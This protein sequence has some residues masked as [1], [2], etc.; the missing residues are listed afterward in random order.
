MAL[1]QFSVRTETVEIEGER[2]IVRGMYRVESLAIQ[3]ELGEDPELDEVEMRMLA[4]GLDVPLI[5][6]R[7][8]YANLPSHVVDPLTSAI[9]RLSGL[10]ETEGRPT[11]SPS[12]ES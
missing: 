1:P 9:A 12:P 7:D 5:E 11:Q 8:W 3:R 6:I 4:A 2:F 10:G